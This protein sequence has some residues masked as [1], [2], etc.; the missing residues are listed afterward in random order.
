MASGLIETKLLISSRVTLEESPDAYDK[1]L[2][3][4]DIAAI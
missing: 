2:T 3:G 4:R 1:V